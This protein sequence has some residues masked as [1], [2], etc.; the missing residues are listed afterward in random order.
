MDLRRG[1]GFQMR[2]RFTFEQRMQLGL[3]FSFMCK[4]L[5]GHSTVSVTDK[6]NNTVI[7]DAAYGPISIRTSN[8]DN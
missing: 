2:S 6:D 3:V 4:I 8:L 7:L 1:K 5:Q